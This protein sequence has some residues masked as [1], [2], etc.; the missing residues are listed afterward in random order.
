MLADGVLEGSTL[1]AGGKE[2]KLRLSGRSLVAVFGMVFFAI[3]GIWW[4]NQE[5]RQSLS[6]LEFVVS[7]LKITVQEFPPE[8]LRRDIERLELELQR[9][10]VQIDRIEGWDTE[11]YVPGGVHKKNRARDAR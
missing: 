4:S 11:T 9:Q 7:E 3:A 1:E 6:R 8:W 5:L 10:Q 2:I